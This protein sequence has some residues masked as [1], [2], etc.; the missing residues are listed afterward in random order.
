M[1]SPSHLWPH[2]HTPAALI[3][4]VPLPQQRESSLIF[5]I[6]RW[7]HGRRHGVCPRVYGLYCVG[8]YARYTPGTRKAACLV[9]RLTTRL[10]HIL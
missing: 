8:Q 3:M 7:H 5:L 4:Q 1:R 2:Q 6:S 10:R 9:A